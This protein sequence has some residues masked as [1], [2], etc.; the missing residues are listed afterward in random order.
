MRAVWLFS[1]LL[2]ACGSRSL[3]GQG[4][5]DGFDE[6]GSGGK[7]GSGSTQGGR[8]S[9]GGRPSNSSGGTSTSGGPATTGGTFTRGGA[10]TS[11]GVPI[12]FGGAPF[13]FGGS[14][15]AAGGAPVAGAAGFGA[16]G[17]FGASPGSGGTDPGN[18]KACDNFCGSLGEACLDTPAG[19]EDGCVGG[20]ASRSEACQLAGQALFNCAGSAL[21]QPGVDCG[22]VF[23]LVGSRCALQFLAF[24]ACAGDMPTAPG[25]AC[26][27]QTEEGSDYC[28]LIDSCQ[29]A[30]YD[31]ICS[32][33][34]DE[35]GVICACS[36]DGVQRF[37]SPV[38]LPGNGDLCSLTRALNCTAF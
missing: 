14:P 37:S 21:R 22:D 34:G 28:H 15:L 32:S 16:V 10:P 23:T 26:A 30:I 11:G 19:C 17:G 4:S 8:Q 9:A 36:V 33:T 5:F 31:S 27:R 35:Q 20:L 7:S 3:P 38:P 12:G 25:P 29:T 6:G 1:S 18:V 24:S 13:N 2:L